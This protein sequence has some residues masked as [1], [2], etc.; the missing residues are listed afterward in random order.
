MILLLHGIVSLRI[1]FDPNG[2]GFQPR[3]KG[4]A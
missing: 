4:T 2:P 1:N 3:L